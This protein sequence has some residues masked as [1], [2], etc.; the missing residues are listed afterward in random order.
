MKKFLV[1]L[2]VASVVVGSTVWWSQR[3]ETAN[4]A[5]VA[6]TQP[7]TPA[8]MVAVQAKLAS[9]T[10]TRTVSVSG[11]VEAEQ[12]TTLRAQVAGFVAQLPIALGQSVGVGATLAVIDDV[13]SS[14][15]PEDG[16]RS[17]AYQQSQID[18]MIA[19]K[20]YDQAKKN[21]QDNKTSAT[22]TE[23]EIAKLNAE[24]ALNDAIQ[25]AD[26][27]TVRAPF[28]GVVAEKLVNQGDAVSVGQAIATVAQG[29]KKVV[30]FFVDPSDA[31]K[32]STKQSVKL[33][34]SDGTEYPSVVTRIAPLPDTMTRKVL[35]EA[36]LPKEAVSVTVA[37][38]GTVRMTLT[39]TVSAP[40]N[41]LLPLEAVTTGQNESFIFTEENGIAKKQAVIVRRIAGE[42]AEVAWD[43][44]EEARIIT[45]GAKQVA[46]GAKVS[47]QE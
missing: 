30:R 37:T 25:A 40:G 22:K 39:D 3:H 45:Q 16:L 10:A 42:W 36:M 9:H 5:P 43:G 4:A 35:V 20:R 26:T 38:L 44:S 47:I 1:S 11:T 17:S 41:I 33:T 28:G 34:L 31:S 46:D 21:Y 32:L 19:R 6:Q 27:H 8:V 2:G 29:S 24:K 13:T 23:R 7:Q 14:L 15:S 18:E 12:S